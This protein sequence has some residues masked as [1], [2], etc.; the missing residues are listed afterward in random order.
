MPGG[1]F[2]LANPQRLA[3]QRFGARGVALERAIFGEIEQRGRGLRTVFVTEFVIH[4][5]S[6]AVVAL[7]ARVVPPVKLQQPEVAGY[8]GSGPSSRSI[9][10]SKNVECLSECFLRLRVVAFCL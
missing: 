1:K 5:Q 4:V 7:G 10:L 6:L 9:C 3:K 2:F 8:F